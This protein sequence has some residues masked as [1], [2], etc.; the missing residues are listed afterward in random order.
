MLVVAVVALVAAA[1]SLALHQRATELD[2]YL[3]PRPLSDSAL[4]E[5]INGACRR[6]FQVYD[7]TTGDEY[8]PVPKGVVQVTCVRYHPDGNFEQYKVAVKR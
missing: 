5:R 4:A 8:N 6:G 7:W 2:P 3:A 1:A